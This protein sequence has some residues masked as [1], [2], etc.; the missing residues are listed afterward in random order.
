[1]KNL[2]V[3]NGKKTSD[4]T[5]TEPVGQ[6]GRGDLPVSDLQKRAEE[7]AT[8]E[9]L[10]DV[11]RE[12]EAVWSHIATYLDPDM[13]TAAKISVIRQDLRATE[14][15]NAKAM[16]EKWTQNH[17]IKATR[18]RLIKAMY[19]NDLIAE[20]RKVFETTHKYHGLVEYV[21]KSTG[22]K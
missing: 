7:K 11:A 14:F 5:S 8:Q 12:I 3:D 22:G 16:L 20:A 19:D 2:V 4:S 15:M 6:P 9:E 21:L 18:R 1:M 13:F 17:D 10:R